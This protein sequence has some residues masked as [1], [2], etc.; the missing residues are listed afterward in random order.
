MKQEIKRR[1][2]VFLWGVIGQPPRKGGWWE[3]DSV[4]NG[5]ITSKKEE[6][7]KLVHPEDPDGAGNGGDHSGTQ[8]AVVCEKA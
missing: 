3:E 6:G 7:E 8:A 2:G 5:I 1:E 4:A